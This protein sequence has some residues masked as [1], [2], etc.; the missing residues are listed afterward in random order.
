MAGELAALRARLREMAHPV[1]AAH[2]QRFFKTGPGEYGAGENA[3]G[4][5]RVQEILPNVVDVAMEFGCPWVMYW[6]L[7]CNEAKVRPVVKNEDTKG[8]WLIKPDGSKAW[9]WQFLHDRITAQPASHA[10][11]GEKVQLPTSRRVN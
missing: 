8:M 6:Q 1:V 2:A 4:L 7:Y 9:A 11:P 10:K 5:P 3:A